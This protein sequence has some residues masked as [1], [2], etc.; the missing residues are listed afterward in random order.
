ML[1]HEVRG[2]EEKVKFDGRNGFSKSTLP[3]LSSLGEPF[4][5]RF[6]REDTWDPQ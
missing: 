5:R 2:M 1:L 6:L 3:V 4:K